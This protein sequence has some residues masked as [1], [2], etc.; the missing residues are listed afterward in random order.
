MTTAEFVGETNRQPT[1]T[2]LRE[3]CFHITAKTQTCLHEQATATS[4]VEYFIQ[5]P[6]FCSKFLAENCGFCC[7]KRLWSTHKSKADLNEKPELA[8]CHLSLHLFSHSRPSVQNKHLMIQCISTGPRHRNLSSLFSLEMMMN[9]N[10]FWSTAF[11][12]PING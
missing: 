9:E 4:L 1:V 10:V 11:L 6:C 3:S 12:Y 7:H 8:S 5:D 2:S